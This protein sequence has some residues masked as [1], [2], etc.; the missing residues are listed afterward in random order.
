MG[1]PQRDLQMAEQS[2][3]SLSLFLSFSTGPAALV[4]CSWGA[5]QGGT[6]PELPFFLVLSKVHV[7]KGWDNGLLIPCKF[8]CKCHCQ[9]P[10]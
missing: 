8:L 7:W 3:G 6:P 10:F 9:D 1:S 5:G 2:E 4:Q